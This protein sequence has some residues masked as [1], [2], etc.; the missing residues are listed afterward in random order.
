MGPVINAPIAA[1]RVAAVESAFSNRSWFDDQSSVRDGPI[2]LNEGRR[3]PPQSAETGAVGGRQPVSALYPQ[4]F[5]GF[6][7]FRDLASPPL[8]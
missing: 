4:G 6:P 5:E 1:V 2:V 3:Q 7:L 8:R